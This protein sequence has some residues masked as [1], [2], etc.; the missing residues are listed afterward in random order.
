MRAHPHGLFGE[1]PEICEELQRRRELYGI[2]Y[3]TVGAEARD[4]FAPV[5]AELS[6]T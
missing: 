4:A 6:G 3:V 1:V 5:V 2:S